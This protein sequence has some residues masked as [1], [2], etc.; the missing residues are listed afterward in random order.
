MRCDAPLLLLLLL[1]S[2]SSSPSSPALFPSRRFPMELD[3]KITG[4]W[5][6]Y[7]R[8]ENKIIME[9]FLLFS[10]SSTPYRSF[11]TSPLLHSRDYSL[12]S[13]FQLRKKIEMLSESSWP[14]HGHYS[15]RLGS[16]TRLHGSMGAISDELYIVLWYLVH[17]VQPEDISSSSSS[18]SIPMDKLLGKPLCYLPQFDVFSIFHI[19]EK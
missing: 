10:S 3:A 4:L 5:N 13:C 14:W 6:F 11:S 2:A 7:K 9:R 8:K 17:K 1:S 18:F 19:K 15:A 12:F 16:E